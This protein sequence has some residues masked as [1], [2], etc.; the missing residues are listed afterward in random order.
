M[1]M[2]SLSSL[3]DQLSDVVWSI[4]RREGGVRPVHSEG[5]AAMANKITAG[6]QMQAVQSALVHVAGAL[7]G[8]TKPLLLCS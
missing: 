7:L 1:V 3:F 6:N 2:L 4:G 5:P 8:G